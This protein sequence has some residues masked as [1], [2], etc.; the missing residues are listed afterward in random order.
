MAQLLRAE[1]Q[2]APKC[3][4][5]FYFQKPLGPWRA[6]RVL[7]LQDALDA[8]HG[9][10]EW[11]T[12]QIYTDGP[13]RIAQ[14]PGEAPCSPAQHRLAQALAFH[15][16]HGGSALIRARTQLAA[17]EAAGSN[18]VA[19]ALAEVVEELRT[20]HAH[21]QQAERRARRANEW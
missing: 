18:E 9:T 2:Q 5:A 13:V 7:A 4:R 20:L 12:G 8:G 11:E 1:P 21:A 17:A 10:R 6:R 3:F 14:Q 16:K 19:A 15:R